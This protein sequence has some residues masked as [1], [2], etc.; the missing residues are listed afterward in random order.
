MNRILVTLPNWYGETLF[1]TPFLRALRQQL[2]QA[3]IVT[4]GRPACREVLLHNPHINELLDYDERG[5][6]QSLAGKWQLIQAVRQRRFETAFILRKSLSRT[7]M[8]CAAGIPRRIGFANPKSGWLLTQRVP[9]AGGLRHKAP[10]YLPLL[11]AV[12]LSV[13]PGPYEYTV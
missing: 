11:E 8:L 9:V 1:A 13:L 7:L 4:L 12:G 3:V 5:A 6:H 2:P 10:T